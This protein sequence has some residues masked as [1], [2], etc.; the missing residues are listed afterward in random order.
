MSCLSKATITKNSLMEIIFK[1]NNFI[2]FSLIKLRGLPM[3]I[4]NGTL[5]F[6]IILVKC[7][8]L[9]F[10]TPWSVTQSKPTRRWQRTQIT[11]HTTRSHLNFQV[12][13][14]DL[15]D[16]TRRR[17]GQR[18]EHQMFFLLVFLIIKE[19]VNKLGSL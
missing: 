5:C 15:A 8:V 17:N 12:T 9:P 2:H 11:I 14:K 19:A 3:S 7:K 16:L 13:T 18:P 6:L 10:A 1:P 4:N